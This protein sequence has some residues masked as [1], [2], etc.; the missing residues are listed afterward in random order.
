MTE[1]EIY[2]RFNLPLLYWLRVGDDPKHW[3]GPHGKGAKGWNDPARSYDLARFDSAVHNLGTFTGR[4]IAPNKHLTDVD[5]DKL[6]QL[7]VTA[8]FPKEGTFSI[9]RPGKAPSHLLYTTT[10][11]KKSRTQYKALSDDQ[12]YIEIRGTGCQTML[13]P[14]L[15]TPPDIRVSLLAATEIRHVDLAIL[16]RATLDYSIAS[17]V[18]EVFYGG[19]HHDARVA[20]AGYL[21]KRRFAEARVRTLLQTICASQVA[22]GVPD[23][24][25]YDVDDAAVIV[26]TTAERLKQHEKVIGGSF[27]NDVNKDFIKHLASWLPRVEGDVTTDDF[28]AYMP[29]HSYLFLPSGEFWPASSVDA[30]VSPIVTGTNGEGEEETL[31]AHIWLDHHRSVEQMTWAPGLPMIVQDRLVSDGGWIDR[32]GCAC[33]NLYR[34]PTIGPGDATKAEPWLELVRALYPE[35]VDHIVAWLAHRVQRPHEKINHAL[36]LGGVPG[37]GKDTILEPVKAAVGPWNFAEIS[38]SHLLGRFNGFVKSVI[39]RISEARDLGDMNRYAFYEH[40]K[41]YAAAPP[42]VLRVDE[43]NIR[44]HAVFNVCGV[45]MTTN[46]EADGIYLPP[47]DRRHFVAWSAMTPAD[48]AEGYWRNTYAWYANGGDRHVAAYL[49]R[50]DLSRF[51]AKAPPLKTDA[52]WAIV[53]ANRSSEDAELA[54]LFEL[55]RNPNAVTLDMLIEAGTGTM[56]DLVAWLGDRKN[57]RVIPHRMKTADYAP[58]RN[59]MAKDGLW[60]I[61]GRRR[62][63]YVRQE[64]SVRERQAAAEGLANAGLKTADSTEL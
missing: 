58:F 14:S 34:P 55:C 18:V 41:V 45:V 33:V 54:D 44:E 61:D 27:F 38:P 35:H 56:S 23:M 37:I 46:H 15:H 42:D 64:L 62:V 43:K 6:N 53:D 51:D 5:F 13:P 19:L 59:P 29:D 57:S 4:E 21:L 40:M 36:V 50:Y 1:V 30:K 49:A 47:D 22:R 9:G 11:Q 28:Y 3:K 32:V 12:P 26:A 20:L 2:R 63:V 7:F 48:F 24:S 8:F 10:P 52:F 16:E 25:A 39:L 17:L 60:K 31:P